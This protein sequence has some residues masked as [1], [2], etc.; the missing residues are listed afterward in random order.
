MSDNNFSPIA[1]RFA[2]VFGY[3]PR[4]R[5]DVVVNMFVGMAVS[6]Q[7]ITLNSNGQAWRPHLYIDDAC[8]SIHR[9]IGC[10]YN[11]GELLVLNVG[12]NSNNVRI[13]DLVS[14]LKGIVPSLKLEVMGQ[15]SNSNCD[16]F[17]DRKIKNGI[18]VRTYK[19]DFSKIEKIFPGYVA[20]V[21]LQEGISKLY[22]KLK[23]IQLD[24]R[25]FKD[26]GFYRLQ[27]LEHL[28]AQGKI[29]SQ[30]VWC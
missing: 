5:F 10:D 13:I 20:G 9:A 21:S 22:T 8:E 16:L 28:Q 2:T 4:M 7:E 6:A 12:N 17:A 19:V 27:Q 26:R 3:S 24:N 25:K 29:N 11:H 30:L 18:D 15:H 1:L 14:I 23:E